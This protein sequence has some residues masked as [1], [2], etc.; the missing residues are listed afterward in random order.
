AAND[1]IICTGASAT[2]TGTGGTSYLWSTGAVTAS[3]TVTPA[4]TTT[5][6]VTV[7]NANGCTATTTRTITV[8]S[9]PTAFNV[10]GG[11]AYCIQGPGLPVGLSGSQAGVNYQLQRNAVNVGAVVPGTGNP[12]TFGVF[13][14]IG[15]YTVVATNTSTGCTANMTGAV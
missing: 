7:T 14:T 6:T 12:L 15:S 8:N 9:L 5:Y 10:T 11:G 13:T 3:I 2:I 1:G 4:V